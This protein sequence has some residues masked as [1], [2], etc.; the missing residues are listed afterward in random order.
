MADHL[1]QE[2]L[3]LQCLTV[4]LWLLWLLSV[5]DIT[6]LN[7][8]QAPHGNQRVKGCAVIVLYLLFHIYFWGWAILCQL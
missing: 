5:T 3:C 7:I 6:I 1:K 8:H 2:S 4:T